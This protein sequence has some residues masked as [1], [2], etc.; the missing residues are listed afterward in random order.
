LD[1]CFAIK[2]F[3]GYNWSEPSALAEGRAASAAKT[4]MVDVEFAPENEPAGLHVYYSLNTP[5]VAAQTFVPRQ[6]GISAISLFGKRNGAFTLR[7]CEGEV[8][9]TSGIE[10]NWDCDLPGQRF[11]SEVDLPNDTFPA[12]TGNP[13]S[14]NPCYGPVVFT[15]IDLPSPVAITPGLKHFFILSGPGGVTLVGTRKDR[16]PTADY[17]DGDLYVLTFADKDLIFRTHYVVD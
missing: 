3:N 10:A 13:T 16:W 12:C 2:T 14:P 6:S 8:D 11:L 15:K 4:E 7:L 5:F 9:I 1:Y 17:P